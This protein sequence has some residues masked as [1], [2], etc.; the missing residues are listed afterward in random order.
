MF[1][2]KNGFEDI[3]LYLLEKGAKV[4]IARADGW[5]RKPSKN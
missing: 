1:A 4:D 2:I 3:A 5:T